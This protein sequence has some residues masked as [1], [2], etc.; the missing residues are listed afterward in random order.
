[1]YI[2]GTISY[3]STTIWTAEALCRNRIG[4]PGVALTSHPAFFAVETTAFSI[5]VTLEDE[6][7]RV[8]E[9]ETLE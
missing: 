8:V 6:M 2:P 1:M 9:L 4:F 7:N 3:F 5:S